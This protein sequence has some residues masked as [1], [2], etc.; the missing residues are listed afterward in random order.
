ML[1]TPADFAVLLL[2]PTG[3]HLL[4]LPSNPHLSSLPTHQKCW[5]PGPH[6]VCAE[7]GEVPQLTKH[8]NPAHSTCT[9]RIPFTMRYLCPSWPDQLDVATWL[10][11][12]SARSSNRCLSSPRPLEEGSSG[13]AFPLALLSHFPPCPSN[14]FPWP[15]PSTHGR[16]PQLPG[17]QLGFLEA[18]ACSAQS[19][20]PCLG[21]PVSGHYPCGP[22]SRDAG[23]PT[24]ASLLSIL[25]PPW[26][27]AHNGHTSSQCPHARPHCPQ[28]QNQLSSDP[29]PPPGATKPP[30][31]GAPHLP[32]LGMK[33][34]SAPC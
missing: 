32:L 11:S 20:L 25:G 31:L 33:H 21:F 30:L 16:A 22:W 28:S 24:L 1:T 27:R 14:C 5:V 23:R 10:A 7:I 4:P 3:S 29:S 34:R 12:I 19:V 26:R 6:G 2:C 8:R 15:C 13:P 18:G 9:R 17:P